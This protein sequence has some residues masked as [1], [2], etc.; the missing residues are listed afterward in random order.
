MYFRHQVSKENMTS[1]KL[2]KEN[3]IHGWVSR[4]IKSSRH[5]YEGIKK[6]I[7]FDI[8]K[9]RCLVT[10]KS[11]SLYFYN[12]FV[13]RKSYSTLTSAKP[14]EFVTL[15]SKLFQFHDAVHHET[16]LMEQCCI[17]KDA[18]GFY[19]S[20][21]VIAS[22]AT[23]YQSGTGWNHRYRKTRSQHD[24]KKREPKIY[25][26]YRKLRR[27]WF[28][29][30]QEIWY[31]MSY[32]W[33]IRCTVEYPYS[34]LTPSQISIGSFIDTRVERWYLIWSNNCFGLLLC[35]LRWI[36]LSLCLLQVLLLII[37]FCMSFIA[38]QS[39][40][41]SSKVIFQIILKLVLFS[42]QIGLA[43]YI[44]SHNVVSTI[45]IHNV[46]HEFKIRAMSLAILKY[47]N[48]LKSITINIIVC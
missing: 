40:F 43:F 7:S 46:C 30:Q 3:E 48:Q 22:A 44:T 8:N 36:H 6:Y 28:L 21:N 9:K 16:Y 4:K 13:M 11:F 41:S 42:F 38:L 20:Q 33:S 26:L 24:F 18:P 12:R 14:S 31:F 37:S 1:S 34:Q 29:F 35:K 19:H 17:T 25:F 27:I 45:N 2:S 39:T 47:G 10:F 5:T 23:I 15:N 32:L